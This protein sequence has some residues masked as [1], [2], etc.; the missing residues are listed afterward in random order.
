M[1]LQ[2][3]KIEYQDL[4][5]QFLW[6][7]WSALGIAGYAE[8]DDA[9]VIDPEALLLFSTTISRYDQRLFD[10]IL[11]WLNKNE[12]FINIQRLKT[13]LYKEQFDSKSVIGAVA[14][15]IKKKNRGLK[16]KSLAELGKKSD[17]KQPL[18]FLK[19]GDFLPV[20]QE[21]DPLFLEYGLSRN[22][23]QHRELSNIFTPKM[24][25]GLL[26]QLR[27]FMGLTSRS[28]TLLYL[29][30]NERGT[31]QE[32]ADATYYSWRSIQDVLFEMAHSGVLNFP[33]AKKGRV[34]SIKSAPWLKL[35]L[36]EE[37]LNIDWISWP[38]LFR[39]LEVL[40]L[41]L[42]DPEFMQDSPLAQSAELRELV[43]NEI[44]PRFEK[45]GI[46]SVLENPLGYYGEEYLKLLLNNISVL[47]R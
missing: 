9:W 27:A 30:I 43:K 39:A 44:A 7:Q 31:I 33:I 28:E 45:A 46:G 8:S 21:N 13:I 17:E 6:R 1:Q 29:L 15:T 37:D 4:L 25:A 26:L 34:Y 40:W 41:K 38:P 24:R 2:E 36:K 5:L 23:V 20:L 18:F 16:W 42:N 35:L 3:F 22:L 12:R 11:D 32:I 19:S 10:E 47:L 14:G